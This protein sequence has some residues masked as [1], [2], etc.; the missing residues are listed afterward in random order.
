MSIELL[1]KKLGMTQI[2]T[3][4][5]EAIGVTALEAS[6]NVVVQKKTVDKDGYVAVQLAV[7]ERRESLFSKAEKTHFEKNGVPAP[8][9]YLSR[10][11]P[12]RRRGRRT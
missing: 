3:N 11:P 8:K 5:G 10:E 2:F 9:R 1:C 6:P 4:S 7:G 12:N